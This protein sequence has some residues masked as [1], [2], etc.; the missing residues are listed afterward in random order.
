M[1]KEKI[2]WDNSITEKTL[3]DN[4]RTL[5]EVCDRIKFDENYT[6]HKKKINYRKT[7]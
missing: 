3:E 1:S 4:N 5:G 6:I 2:V 7:K